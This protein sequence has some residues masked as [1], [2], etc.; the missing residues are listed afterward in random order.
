MMK[1]DEKTE[2]QKREAPL[3]RSAHEFY[4]PAMPPFWLFRAIA[5]WARKLYGYFKQV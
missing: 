2:A 3:Q 1:A 5:R 4:M